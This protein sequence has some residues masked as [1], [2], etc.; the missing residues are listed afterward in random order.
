MKVVCIPE[1]THF[2]EPKLML[3]DYQFETMG[4]FLED[5]SSIVQ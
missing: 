1:K 3:A 5:I 2:P 4:G